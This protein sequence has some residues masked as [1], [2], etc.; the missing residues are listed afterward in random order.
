MT[1]R[2]TPA[3]PLPTS[4]IPAVP[5]R[6][7]LGP[8]PSN[9][10]PSVLQAMMQPMI[11][12]LDPDF[13]LIMDE[14]RELLQRV[15]QTDDANTL[16]IS[17]TGSSGM[18]AGLSS[19]LEPGD[20]VVMCIYGFFCERMVEMATRIGANVVPLRADWGRPFPEE[21]LNAELKKHTNVKM[22]TAIHAETST[23]VRQP[24]PDL[25]RLAKEHDALFM[26]DTVT[27]LGGN[28]VAF[29]EWDADYAYSATQKCLG[30]PPGLSPVALSQRALQ[31][32]R[33]R[34]QPPVSWYLDLNLL[35]NYWGW[36]EPRVYHHTAPV[37]MILALRQ[38][39]RLALSE[40]LE[41]RFERH[42]HNARALSAGLEAIGLECVVPEEHRLAQITVVGIPDGVE[43]APVRQRLL[44]G[45]G[46]EIGGGL[47]ELAGKVWRVGLM[48]E[49][50]KAE[51]VL[52]LLSALETTLPEFGYEV[53]SGAGVS[54]ASVEL[55]TAA[56]S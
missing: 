31:S 28:E 52:A 46:I 33:D 21:M 18:E 16:A 29:D 42:A 20:T 14:V 3:S 15:F 41:S 9:A 22:V 1:Q 34:S 39:L 44:R 6:I 12:Y 55:G 7:L 11:G 23:G 24:M 37:S 4:K 10:N 30:C 49:S 43:D 40:G 45:F 25:A 53:A 27:S 47:G 17:G 50:S 56:V 26:V 38:G 2:S 13:M 35:G 36:T 48:G 19:L 32:I 8:G 5:P 51:Y 54:A